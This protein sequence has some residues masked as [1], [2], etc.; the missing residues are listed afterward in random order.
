[1]YKPANVT[2]PPGQPRN[3]VVSWIYAL[4]WPYGNKDRVIQLPITVG[5]ATVYARA[6]NKEK[7]MTIYKSKCYCGRLF[8]ANHAQ[9]FTANGEASCGCTKRDH[10]KGMLNWNY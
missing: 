2:S 5:F 6:W 4:G 1:M 3:N 10:S 7:K 9:L 8:D